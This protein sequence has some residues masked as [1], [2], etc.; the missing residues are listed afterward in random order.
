[1]MYKKGGS[2]KDVQGVI[3]EF[4]NIRS[5]WQLMFDDLGTAMG[6]DALTEFAPLFGKKFKD[7]LGSTYEIFRNKSVIPL[8]NYKPSEQAVKKMMQLFKESAS[9]SGV[10]LIDEQAEYYVN[11]LIKTAQLPKG[12]KMDK[13]SNVV[14]QIP[15]FFAGKTVLDDAITSK[16]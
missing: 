9:E 16:G 3:N 10:K 7:Y 6:K 1:M 13:P 12:F 11:R 14:F 15:D 8:L 4:Y 5:G 2:K